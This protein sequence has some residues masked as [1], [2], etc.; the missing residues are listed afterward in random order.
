M[1]EDRPPRRQHRSP[2]LFPAV[3][4]IL[5]GC[6]PEAPPP[7]KG[8]AKP[9]EGLKLRLIVVEDPAITLA[10]RALRDEW[11]RRNRAEIEVAD[12]TEKQLFEVP[13][14]PG[15]A[16]ILPEHLLGPLA[17]AKALAPVPQSI[18]RD[19]KNPWSQTFELLRDQEA[20]WGNE[21]FGVPLG[22]PV[23]CCYYRADLLEKLHRKPPQTWKEYEELARLLRAEGAKSG[24][25]KYGTAEPLGRGWAGL[26]L[27]AGRSLR[28]GT[29]QLHD[30]LR[31]A[32]ARTSHRRSAFP[33]GF[34][35]TESRPR[36]R[37]AQG[38]GV[39]SGR[40]SG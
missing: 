28:Q 40:R 2:W 25:P 34:G 31:R 22:S 36:T 12:A 4:L 18:A 6:S 35:G 9:L 27:L 11:K 14:L 29:R 33:T 37:S 20:V 26:L 1:N 10:V 39:R 15:D 5:V 30:A 13:S 21:V 24:G 3:L 19:L 32:D 7:T 23:L 16:V 17:E 8:S 38:T